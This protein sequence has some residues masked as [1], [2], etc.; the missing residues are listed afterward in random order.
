MSNIVIVGLL[1]AATMGV[2]S[3]PFNM[4][5]PNFATGA[6]KVNPAYKKEIIINVN[7]VNICLSNSNGD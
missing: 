1:P 4:E 6:L 5:G 3:F 7:V 2:A